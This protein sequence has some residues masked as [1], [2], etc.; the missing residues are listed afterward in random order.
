MDSRDRERARVP[1]QILSGLARTLLCSIRKDSLGLK[2][3]DSHE[4]V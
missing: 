2:T 4:D 3:E 1:G